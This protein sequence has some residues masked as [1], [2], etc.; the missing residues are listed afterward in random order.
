M[1]KKIAIKELKTNLFV[2]SSLDQDWV[3]QLAEL[4]EHGVKLPPIKINKDKQVI[5]GRHRIEAYELNNITEIEYELDDISDE[6]ELIAAAYRANCGGSLPPRAQDTEHVVRLLL[7][8]NENGK[9]IADLLGLPYGIARKLAANVRSKDERAA[10]QRAAMAVTDAGLTIPQ[11][12]E[13]YHADEEKVRTALGGKGRK[14][15]KGIEEMQ[16]G[17]TSQHKTLG[18]KNAALLRSLLEK[19]EDGDISVRQVNDIFEHLEN[20]QKRQVRTLVDWKK[21]FH[22]SNGK[23]AVPKAA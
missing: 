20:L 6:K 16:R 2:R 17:L 14:H 7:A 10:V 22:A 5:D 12:A 3:L 13:Q 15:K 8:R 19:Y 23:S 11:A 9:T 21:R 1:A 18:L 4:I